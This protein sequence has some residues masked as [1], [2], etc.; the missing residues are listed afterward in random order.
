MLQSDKSGH[1]S[2]QCVCSDGIDFDHDDLALEFV[3]VAVEEDDL[4][5]ACSPHGLGIVPAVWSFY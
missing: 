5:V 2:V 4:V 3:A 1:V